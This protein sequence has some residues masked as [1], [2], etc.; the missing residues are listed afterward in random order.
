MLE[1][2]FVPGE[3]RYVPDLT[4]HMVKRPDAPEWNGGFEMCDI[5]GGHEMWVS[6]EEWDSF[7]MEA[8]H[9]R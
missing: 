9:G 1:D 2:E 7:P 4:S 5:F 3:C 8:Q 6:N